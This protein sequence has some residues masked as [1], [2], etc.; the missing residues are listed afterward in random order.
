MSLFN[1]TYEEELANQLN[2]S[3]KQFQETIESAKGKLILGK[4]EHIIF[5]D[6]TVYT[7]P[8]AIRDY[9]SGRAGVRIMKGV[10]IG[11]TRGR[12]ESH[13]ELRIVDY[14]TL[15]ITNKKLVFIGKFKTLSIP[16]TSITTIT[17]FLD[18]VQVSKTGKERSMYF[19]ASSGF[20][21]YYAIKNINKYHKLAL[22]ID[23]LK[24]IDGLHIVILNVLSGGNAI[25][26]EG[27]DITTKVHFYLDETSEESSKSEKI[28][29]NITFL[30]K[31][32]P[33][34]YK[35]YSVITKQLP[36][37]D[38]C[39]K[40]VVKY[41]NHYH[42]VL[43][44][45]KKESKLIKP[46][47][48]IEI[49]GYTGIKSIFKPS[50]EKVMFKIFEKR[51]NISLS[52]YTKPAVK[53]LGDTLSKMRTAYNIT[54]KAMPKSLFPD[55]SQNEDDSEEGVWQCEYCNK[56]FDSKKDAE[57]HEKTC[58]KKKES[59]VCECCGKGF[60]SKEKAEAHEKVCKECVTINL[61]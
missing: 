42:D 2:I 20:L 31:K 35:K 7:E 34:D 23:Y 57:A 51:N 6:F 58:E 37:M 25:V 60:E 30:I 19:S 10:W 29:K 17:P 54:L 61:P 4:G 16:I 53:E 8:R 48:K 36:E 46:K 18:A 40:D 1:I 49:E 33:A 22:L 3:R 59:W 43:T 27:T 56:E 11:G 50:L 47:A 55:V 52:D 13:Q 28:L 39:F 21:P 32:L 41:L 5:H 38:E 26:H 9:I 12:S 24:F 44:F 45:L 14:G 15:T